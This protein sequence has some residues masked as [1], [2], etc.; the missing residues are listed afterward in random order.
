MR[1]GLRRLIGTAAAIAAVAATAHSAADEAA[2]PRNTSGVSTIWRKGETTNVGSS[3]EFREGDIVRVSEGSRLTIEYDDESRISL[4][5]PSS[6]R[7]GPM[8]S[9]GRRVVLGS[10]AAS[11]VVVHGIAL[12]IQAPNPHDASLVMQNARGMAR[13]N[14]GDRIVFQRSVGDF[15]KVWREN[16]YIDLGTDPWTLNVRG[17]ATGDPREQDLGDDTVRIMLNGVEIVISP[18][19]QFSRTWTEDGGLSM[20]YQGAGDSFGEVDVGQE[21]SVYV[22]EGQGI[23]FDSNGDITAFSG[24]SHLQRPLFTPVPQDDPTENG[25]NASPSFSRKR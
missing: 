15:G 7:F 6:L 5:G 18:A 10:G 24:V 1:S 19:S 25:Q 16:R 21:T 12:E 20:T 17:G 11:D 2:R 13:V 9:Q 14:P 4:V 22:Y 8:N 23:D 3:T